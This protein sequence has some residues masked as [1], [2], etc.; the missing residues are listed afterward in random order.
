MQPKNNAE[1]IIV[2]IIFPPTS[3]I[4]SKT[5]SFR[6]SMTVT[7]AIKEIQS[8]IGQ[9]T[10]VGDFGLYVKSKKIWLDDKLPL[11]KYKDLLC[12]TDGIDYRNRLEVENTN[13]SFTVFG[14]KTWQVITLS[15]A[16]IIVGG[17]ILRKILS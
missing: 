14:L 1:D 11:S 13:D 16:A 12:L 6:T 3:P 17:F 10:F 15:T 4:A 8:Q 7:D 5:F 2:K 9:K